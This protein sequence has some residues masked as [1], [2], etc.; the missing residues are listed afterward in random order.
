VKLIDDWKRKLRKLWT[1]RLAA[2]G[3]LVGLAADMFPQL[4]G[5]LPDKWYIAVFALIIV[6][7]L[8]AQVDKPNA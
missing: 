2:A 3:T 6:A 5:V 1:T 7:R 4:Q 8:V